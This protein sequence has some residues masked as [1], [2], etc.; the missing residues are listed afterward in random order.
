M[1]LKKKVVG[2]RMKA[3]EWGLRDEAFHSSAFILL[4]VSHGL[5]D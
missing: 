5:T 2:K 1:L 4:P 3:G